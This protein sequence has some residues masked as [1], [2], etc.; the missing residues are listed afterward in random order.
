MFISF[1]FL[2]PL[3][4]APHDFFRYTSH[5]FEALCRRHGFEI[6]EEHRPAV[7]VK[8]P[9]VAN[10]GINVYRGRPQSKDGAIRRR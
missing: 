6:V 10:S 7:P 4:V 2:Y 1:P 9:P 5:G 8:C 3:H